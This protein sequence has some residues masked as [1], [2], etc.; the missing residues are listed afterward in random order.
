MASSSAIRPAPGTLKAAVWQHFGFYEVKGKLDKTYT[1]CKVCGTK[2]K[3]FGN[4]TNLR[5]HISRYH[6]ELEEKRPVPEGSGSQRTIEQALAQ[7]PPNS[8]RAKR[9]TKSIGKFI[10]MDLRPYSVVENEGFREMVHTLEP[11]YKIPCRRYFTDTAIPT[12]YAETKSKVLDTLTNAGRVAIT[13]DAWTSIA[14][15]SYVTVTAHFINND[16]Q[17]VSLVLQ[18]RAMYESHTGANVADLLKKVASEWHLND[19]DLVLVTDNASNMV[20]AAQLGGFVHRALKLPA[21]SKLLAKI[22]RIVSFFHRSTVGAHQLEEKQKLLGLPCHKLI[23]DV[24]TRWNSAYE[25]VRKGE[26]DLCTLTETDVSNAEDVVKALKPMKDATTLIS[27]ESSPTACL[28]APLQAQLCQE[29][30]IIDDSR[31]SSIIREIKQAI[32]EDLRK[33][34]NSDLERS[35]LRSASALDPRFKGL[36]FLSNEDIEETFG[37]V[38]AEAASLEPQVRVEGEENHEENPSPPKR[39]SPSS[40]LE[41]LLGNTFAGATAPQTI[42][43]YTKAEEVNKFCGTPP[44]P[45]SE[46]P[47][48]WWR[49]NEIMYPL[50]SKLGKRYFCIPATSVSAERVFS[51]A[52]DIVTAQRSTLTA[53][54]VDQLLFLHKNLHIA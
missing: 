11:R 41:N 39:R 28:I 4:T 21:L 37:R 26:A 29:T 20:V 35:T 14:T 22:R 18:T 43:A 49:T 23:T 7:L 12:L 46:D 13:C 8:D 51:T 33:R 32:N 10:A 50:L 42:S 38:V 6:T 2:I 52:G 19:N 53:E 24:S 45:L 1:V 36:P 5:N 31:E 34:Y 27:E 44:I 54:H 30:R 48:S 3:Y 40:L 9:I 16:W 17:L 47:L 15:V 25:M